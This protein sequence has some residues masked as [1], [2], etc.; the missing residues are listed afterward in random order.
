MRNVADER[1]S[2]PLNTI[3][4]ALEIKI[5]RNAIEVTC[6]NLVIFTVERF[7]LHPS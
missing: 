5:A 6:S 4:M 2:S 7:N 3:Y 1:E